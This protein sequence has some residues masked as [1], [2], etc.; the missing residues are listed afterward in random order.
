VVSRGSSAQL[1]K[2][3]SEGPVLPSLPRFC[4]PGQGSNRQAECLPVGMG[5]ALKRHQRL[6]GMREQLVIGSA[7]RS[8]PGRAQPFA[9]A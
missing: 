3:C 5:A 7:M 6:Q 8:F 2:L 1:K 4:R 9:A